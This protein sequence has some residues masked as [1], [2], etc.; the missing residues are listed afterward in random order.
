MPSDDIDYLEVFDG[1]NDSTDLQ[2]PM[3]ESVRRLPT[4]RQPETRSKR[5]L[6]R[7]QRNGQ[8]IAPFDCNWSA[9]SARSL[10]RVHC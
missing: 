9:S 4:P 5:Y 10:P 2:K 8:Q 7:S 3:T 6:S 1:I